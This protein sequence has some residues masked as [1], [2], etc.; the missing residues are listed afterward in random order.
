MKY[1]ARVYGSRCSKSSGSIS[2]HRLMFRRITFG[3]NKKVGG[4]LASKSEEVN[5]SS[6]QWGILMSKRPNKLHPCI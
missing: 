5:E 6:E 2:A 1:V 4:T 3:T